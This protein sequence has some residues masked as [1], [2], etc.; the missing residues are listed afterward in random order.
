MASPARVVIF[1]TETT[2]LS[3]AQ[4]DRIVEI[5]CVEMIGFDVGREFH[6]YINPER[7]V[8]E[9][10][11]RVH[12]LTGHFLSTQKLFSSM[13]GELLEF[14]GDD[15]IVAHNAEFDR[16]FLNAELQRCGIGP[17]PKDRFHDTLAQARS[18]MRAGMRLSLDGLAKHFKLDEQRFGLTARKGP[19][20]HGALV[21]AKILAEIYIQLKGGREQRLDFAIEPEQIVETAE[22]VSARQIRQRLAP[23]GFLATASELAEHEK[24][25]GELPGGTNW[26]K[27][28]AE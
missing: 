16:G 18:V 2:G 10:V 24:F 20:G 3:P 15:L 26:P 13:H 8:P 5:G 6:R 21:D 28:S 7:D 27:A 9:E 11:V 14:F 17:F 12:G 1:D 22:R 23:V 4:G 19:G 25:T